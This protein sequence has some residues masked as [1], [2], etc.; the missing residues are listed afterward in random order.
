MNDLIT[1]LRD[2]HN[3]NLSMHFRREVADALEAAEA[4]TARLTRLEGA[5]T[6]TSKYRALE[7]DNARLRAGYSITEGALEEA[8]AEVTALQAQIDAVKALDYIGGLGEFSTGYDLALN[9]VHAIL[10]TTEEEA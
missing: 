8:D 10:S 7:A 1:S 9:E 3:R 6:P 5:F 4:D 2:Y